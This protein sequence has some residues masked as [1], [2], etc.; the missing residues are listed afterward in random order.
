[1]ANDFSYQE[2]SFL[3]ASNRFLIGEIDLNHWFF[4]FPVIFFLHGSRSNRIPSLHHSHLGM[5]RSSVNRHWSCLAEETDWS[6]QDQGDLRAFGEADEEKWS[7]GSLD[8]GKNDREASTTIDRRAEINES[9]TSTINPTQKWNK[10]APS[11]NGKDRHSV[12]C[13]LF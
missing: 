7:L 4:D 9:F 8:N 11:M 12:I 10:S 1:M 2:K 6:G 5:D 3:P 13:P